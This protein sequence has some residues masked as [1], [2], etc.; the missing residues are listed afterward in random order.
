MS[1]IRPRA[2][3][4]RL[5]IGLIAVLAIA[6]TTL[7][8]VTRAHADSD[9]LWTKVVQACLNGDPASPHNPCDVVRPDAD[10]VLVK[11]LCGPTKYLLLPAHKLTGIESEELA[12][13]PNYFAAAWESRDWVAARAGSSLGRPLTPGDFALALNSIDRRSQNQF[14][15]HIDLARPGLS[16]ALKAY[17]SDPVG[18]WSL[19]RF[20]GHDY[21]LSR[22]T[23]L[24]TQ[25]PI[26]LVRARVVAVQGVMRHQTIGLVGATFADGSTGFYL[27]NGEY[28]GTADGGGWA[29][30]LEIDHPRSDCGYHRFPNR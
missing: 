21:H 12:T 8:S 3:V 4:H 23:D 7:L 6:A 18:H 20:N 25:N 2:A 17:Q 16:T 26:L 1:L 15:I 9:A 22:L 28:D 24:G 13:A 19:F 5:M 10:Y 29:E 27:L 30:E 11:D 14:H